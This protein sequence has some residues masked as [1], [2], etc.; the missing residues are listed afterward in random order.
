MS[1]AAAAPPT[2]AATN[3]DRQPHGLR[4]VAS[5]SRFPPAARPCAA[6]FCRVVWFRDGVS[7]LREECLRKGTELAQAVAEALFALP[8]TEDRDVPMVRLPPPH[9]PPPPR[10]AWLGVCQ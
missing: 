5:S 1:E 3:Y 2:A 6:S 9:H 4:P 10:E 7:V 8:A